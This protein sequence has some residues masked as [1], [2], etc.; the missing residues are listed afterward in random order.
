MANDTTRNRQGSPAEDPLAELARL[1]GQEDEFADLLR[2][3]QSARPAPRPAAPAPASAASAARAP[4]PPRPA[5]TRPSAPPSPSAAS[6]APAR[7]APP[8]SFAALAA[9]VFAE[10]QRRPAPSARSSLEETARDLNRAMVRPERAP[11]PRPTDARIDPYASAPRAPAPRSFDRAVEDSAADA[12]SRAL[13]EPFDLAD[14][15]V[16]SEPRAASRATP[17]TETEPPPAWMAR[18]AASSGAAPSPATAREIPAGD[19]AYDYGRSASAEEPYDEDEFVEQNYELDGEEAPRPNRRKLMMVAALL[20]VTVTG[21]AIGY[22]VMSGSRGTVTTS[23]DA[24][25]IHA[26]QGPNKIVPAQPAQ[27]QGSDGQKLIY[28]RVGGSTPTGNERVVSSEE[29]PVD[30]SQA[31]Q[32]QPRVI[33]PAPSPSASSSAN[34]TEPKRVRTLTVRADGSIVED[35]PASPVPAGSAS[36]QSGAQPT[37]SAPIPLSSGSGAPV[38]TS[39]TPLAATP[40]IVPNAP[41]TP[42]RVAAAPAPAASAPAAAGAYVVQIASVRSE[43]EAQA[44]WRSMQAKYPGV[45]GGQSMAVRR[46][47]LGDRGIYYRAQVGSFANR[48]DANALCQALR[49]QGGDCMVQRN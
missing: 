30:M 39:P 32:P 46:A 9:D 47:D 28:D 37:A 36:V 3:T 29:Q 45:L 5:S 44:T 25:V 15:P 31:A 26:E 16:R 43:A 23:G 20:A 7:P 48:D 1:M 19:D 41:N 17:R 18:G 49:S 40:S 14:E 11:A 10:T 22:V 35:A 2:Q 27:E 8:T 33:Q 4:L 12:V 34:A 6:P 42:A 21:V 13:S 24:P 38:S